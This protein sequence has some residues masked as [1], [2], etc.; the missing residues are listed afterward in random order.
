MRISDWSSDVCSSD[1]I[2]RRNF[3]VGTALCG[4][5]R[6]YE[7]GVSNPSRAPRLAALIVHSLFLSTGAAPPALRSALALPFDH[8][9][10]RDFL[11][12]N[13][14]E[15]GRASCLEGVYHLV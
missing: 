2:A 8:I 11:L 3:A 7:L 1:L 9:E 12:C 14:N 15:T 6:P 4:N 13:F 5:M 10:G